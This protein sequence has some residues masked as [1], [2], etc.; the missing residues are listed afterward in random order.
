MCIRD[1]SIIEANIVKHKVKSADYSSMTPAEAVRDF[2]VRLEHYEAQ[3]ETVKCP[4]SSWIKIVNA[5]DQ[6]VVNNIRGYLPGRL[7]SFLTNVHTSP[8]AIYLVCCDSEH[9]AQTCTNWVRDYQGELGGDPELTDQNRVLADK[10]GAFISAELPASIHGNR[11]AVWCS[12]TKRSV[13]M[14]EPMGRTYMTWHA[15]N[16]MDYGNCVGLRVD[17]LPEKLRPGWHERMMLDPL[18]WRFPRGESL[19]DVI[20]RLEPIFVECERQKQ[21]V[22]IISHA[23]VLQVL[24]TFFSDGNPANSFQTNVPHGSVLR[25][26]PH[27]Y[28]CT[29]SSIP[30]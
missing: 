7:V 30:L 8:R 6:L 22:V 5:G 11:V 9:R 12:A 16:E 13:Q 4:D 26:L 17:Q 14:A 25:M 19:V 24:I 2:R 1:R 15:L 20:Q 3:Y 21:P 29:I 18:H 23:T 27:C 28:G 10:L